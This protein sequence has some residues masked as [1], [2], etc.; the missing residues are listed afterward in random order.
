MERDCIT[1][2]ND[3]SLSQSRVAC[4]VGSLLSEGISEGASVSQFPLLHPMRDGD[5]ERT[6]FLRIQLSNHRKFDYWVSVSGEACLD[7]GVFSIV[8]SE[9]D[10]TALVEVLRLLESENVVR[11]FS[12]RVFSAFPNAHLIA[13]RQ[14]GADVT[15]WS[16]FT[17]LDYDEVGEVSEYQADMILSHPN[18]EFDCYIFPDSVFVSEEFRILTRH[19]L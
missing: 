13:Y 11:S 6:E 12:E 4:V 1:G 18:L 2:T 7:Q 10:P 8:K 19:D 16:L 3:Q 5:A 14:R 15:I 9:L 17:D